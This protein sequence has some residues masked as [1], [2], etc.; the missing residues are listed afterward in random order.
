MT[1]SLW[2]V[3]LPLAHRR[4]SFAYLR[5]NNY[6][7]MYIGNYWFEIFDNSTYVGGPSVTNL[8][9]VQTG[10]D[11]VLVSWTAP[12][13]VPTRG[14]QISTTNT[15][16]TTTET[17]HVLTLSQPGNHIVQILP[18]S[19]HFPYNSMSVQAT[20]RGEIHCIAYY[21]RTYVHRCYGSKNQSSTAHFKIS[22]HLLESA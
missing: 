13:P 20:V 6:V 3:K 18:L 1:A 22:F 19:E 11:S 7:R 8:M 9:A 15:E 21:V 12:S 2:K 16:D 14:Y 5:A 17:T 10:L 4:N